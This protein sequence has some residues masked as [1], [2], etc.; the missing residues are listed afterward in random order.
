[1]SRDT[2][3]AIAAAVQTT[4]E[5]IFAIEIGSVGEIPPEETEQ[6]IMLMEAWDDISGKRLDPLKV[7][8]ARAEDIGYYY[9]IQMYDQVPIAECL[10]R[11]GKQPI[12]VRWIDHNKGDDLHEKYRSRLVAQQFNSGPMDDNI[13]AATPPLEALRM[14]ISNATTGKRGKVIMIADVSRAY[15]YARIP[16]D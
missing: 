10:A 13:F 5:G 2:A 3:L 11:T 6:D 9:K 14:V 12:G 4:L 15:M 1:M 8:G 7:E 16:D